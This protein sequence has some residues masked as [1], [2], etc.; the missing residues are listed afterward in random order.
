MWEPS[1]YYCKNCGYYA[2]SQP[3]DAKVCQKCS[4][5]MALLN[6]RYQDFMNLDYA[7]RDFVII[8]QMLQSSPTLSSGIRAPRKLYYKRELVGAITRQVLE[9]EGEIDDLNETIKWMHSVIWEDFYTKQ[10]MKEEIR[11]LKEALELKKD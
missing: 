1:V 6:M 5:P 4:N 9:M 2:F 11:Q 10:Q 7:Q 8:Q 3:H